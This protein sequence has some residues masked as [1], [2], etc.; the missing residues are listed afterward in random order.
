MRWLVIGCF[1]EE[2]KWERVERNPEP[3]ERENF[4]NDKSLEFE[5]KWKDTQNGK[6]ELRR[7]WREAEVQPG[8]TEP[9]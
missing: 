5:L 2:R 6:D 8:K 9:N 4:F 1:V 3:W 7:I